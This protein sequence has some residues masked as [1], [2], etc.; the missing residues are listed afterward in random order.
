[1][2]DYQEYL[3]LQAELST[4]KKMR[5]KIPESDI[6]DRLSIEGR[7]DDVEERLASYEGPFQGPAQ[8]ALTF[9][10]APISGTHGIQANFGGTAIHHFTSAVA[11][12]GASQ[13]GT[14]GERGAIPNKDNFNLLITGTTKGSFGFVIEE[15]S[16]DWEISETKSPVR[17]AIHTTI[18]ILKASTGTDDELNSAVSGSDPQAIKAVRDFLKYLANQEATCSLKSKE[19][20]FTFSDVE[21]IRQSEKKLSENNIHEDHIQCSGYFMG[22]LPEKREFEF[23]EDES[24][25]VIS[26]KVDIT[27]E[28][29]EQINKFLKKQTH[30]KL[31]K[32]RVGVSK[33]ST[34]TLLEYDLAQTT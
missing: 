32:R 26:G 8:F 19:E 5:K 1:M 7:M 13:I 16:K 33:N 6:I 17:S 23:R 25:P 3:D 11:A 28:N 20:E 10:G 18:T 22:Y 27:V 30:I 15:A 34:Y 9:Q 31:M 21:H 29:A 4:L 12:I 24:K 2:I 14:L